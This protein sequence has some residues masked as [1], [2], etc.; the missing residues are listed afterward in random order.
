VC[1]LGFRGRFL[2]APPPVCK[3][4]A[5]PPPSNTSRSCTSR[6][7]RIIHQ[8]Y[9]T[10]QLPARWADTPDAWR[11]THPE[12]EYKFWSDADNRELVRTKYPWFLPT[13][14]GYAHP[15][16]RAD[17]ARYLVVLTY[18]GVYADLDVKPLRDISELLCKVSHE[19]QQMLV[20]ETPNY[21]L[22]NA[23]FA[24]VPN[25]AT[26]EQWVRKLPSLAHPWGGRLFPHLEVMLSAG[27]TRY[28]RFLVTEAEPSSLVR[29]PLGEWGAC[30]NCRSR[31]PA[32]PGAF[33][34]HSRGNSWHNFDT[35]VLNWLNCHPCLIVWLLV[36]LALA[37]CKTLLAR[38]VRLGLSNPSWT[39]YDDV[40]LPSTRSSQLLPGWV[41]D[42]SGFALVVFALNFD[43]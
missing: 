14:D 31:C 26:L 7:P 27:S 37:A 2:F 8:S 22:T 16:S 29:L 30:S 32:E 19:S 12:Y 41:L 23:F 36:C 18:G 38:R 9:K 33:F 42:A 10:S 5:A 25:S 24:A 1:L 13:Y 43:M 35:T 20:T 39:D 28:W 40:A 34:K 6:I 4:C 15:I 17:A 21:G 3:A 11:N